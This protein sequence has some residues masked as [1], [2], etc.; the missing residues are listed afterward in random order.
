M[1]RPA[2]A[3]RIHAAPPRRRS[4]A[5]CCPARRR[6]A[7]GSGAPPPAGRGV[8]AAPPTGGA[9]DARTRQWVVGSGCARMY[10]RF[11][12]SPPHALPSC[13][14]LAFRLQESNQ[15]CP[16]KKTVANRPTATRQSLSHVNRRPPGAASEIPFSPAVYLR[17]SRRHQVS[18]S[19]IWCNRSPVFAATNTSM[20]RRR[21]ALPSWQSKSYA[22]VPKHL[23]Q[24]AS[25]DPRQPAH[26]VGHSPE[27]SIAL[28]MWFVLPATPDASDAVAHEA[29]AWA[30]AAEGRSGHVVASKA[31]I[32]TRHVAV[33][34]KHHPVTHH[35]LC[36][37]RSTFCLFPRTPST[38]ATQ[39]QKMLFC[40]CAP[41]QN[42]ESV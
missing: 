2:A 24:T 37:G 27:G 8:P 21:R 17:H 28:S 40:W 22:P 7:P 10:V 30:K 29:T 11:I 41:A 14:D 31:C 9:G 18:A 42:I 1:R 34:T 6:A 3:A 26:H 38:A 12:H 23:V 36:S 33:Q 19:S 15:I 32:C 35:D 13:G 39:Q 20:R 16:E 25:P 4:A 5:L